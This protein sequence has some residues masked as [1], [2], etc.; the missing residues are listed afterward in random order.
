MNILVPL[1]QAVVSTA[2]ITAM[3]GTYL[4]GPSVHTRRPAPA[5]AE[6]PMAIIGPIIAKTDEDGINSYRPVVV[7]DV[8][9][10]GEQTNEFRVVDE[11]ADAIFRLFHRQRDAIAVAGW[12]VTSI[13]AR[14][15]SPA[16][17]DDDTRVG[18][19]VT[20]T[21]QLYAKN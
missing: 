17:A 18:R 21:I 3:L 7:I 9:T 13:I 2:D 6:Y 10:Y 8:S 4:G 19:R 16:P 15:P 11:I 14:G 1:R 20:L 12:S 5:E